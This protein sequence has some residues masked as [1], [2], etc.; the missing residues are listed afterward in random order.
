[1]SSFVPDGVHLDLPAALYFEQDA[2]GSTDLIRLFKNKYG[3]W[4]SSR[5]NPDRVEKETA[6]QAYGSALHAIV[7]EGVGAYAD[8]FAVEPRWPQAAVDTI[9]QMKD[10]LRQ[11]GFVLRSTSEWLKADWLAAMRQNLPR[12]PVL[13][14]LQADWAERVRGARQVISATDDKMLRLMAD[15]VT[16]ER[17]DNADLR[18]L[19]AGDGGH[20]PLAEISIL[21]TQPDGVRRRWRLDRMFPRFDVDLKSLGNW[22]GRPLDWAVGDIIAKYGYDIQRADYFDGRRMAYEYIRAGKLFG[23]TPEQRSWLRRYPDEFPAWDWVWLFYQKPEAA[24]RAP[25]IFP[26][27]DDSYD[28][29]G[30]PGALRRYGANKKRK[31]LEFYRDAVAEFGLD[32]P[33]A[34]VE[35]VH[36]TDADLSPAIKLPAWIAEEE[37]ADPAAYA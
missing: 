37:A 10:A 29:Q 18:K 25:V 7:L 21:H 8:R 3:W 32:R 6:A 30:G 13:A 31:A 20:P 2:L 26:V 15:V 1:M 14:N 22:A 9:P 12:V 24:G 11:G 35:V 34:R 27:W 36:Y 23:G 19:F 17:A 28:T 4:W 33:W 5:H 16:G